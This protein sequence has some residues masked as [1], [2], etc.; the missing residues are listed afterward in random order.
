MIDLFD[1]A[2]GTTID[3]DGH[4]KMIETL[5]TC[6][7]QVPRYHLL[8]IGSSRLYQLPELFDYMKDRNIEFLRGY[9]VPFSDGSCLLQMCDFEK[10]TVKGR[11]I[12]RMIDSDRS[13]S[14]MFNKV[15]EYLMLSEYLM[16]TT[17]SQ[18]PTKSHNS[19]CNSIMMSCACGATNKRAKSQ[20]TP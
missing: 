16:P 5:A 10:T 1:A 8:L 12:M 9:D 14:A 17:A 4:R 19:N 11:G 13:R 7:K 20:F 15:L 18:W 6:M 3:L 2:A